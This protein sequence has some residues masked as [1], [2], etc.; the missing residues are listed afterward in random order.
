M[1]LIDLTKVIKTKLFASYLLNECLLRTFVKKCN[2]LHDIY[3]SLIC[4]Y[5]I[6]WRNNERCGIGDD[7]YFM[8]YL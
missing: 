2:F 5:V 7:I 1:F 6:F 8:L 4:R 3:I